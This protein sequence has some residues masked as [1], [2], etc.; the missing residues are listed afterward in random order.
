MG[1]DD[2]LERRGIGGRRGMGEV[3]KGEEWVEWGEEQSRK[4]KEL[5]DGCRPF[6]SGPNR[7]CH[8]VQASETWIRAINGREASDINPPTVPMAF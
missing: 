6:C 7:D 3:G 1:K 8:W 4:K 2:A 5:P